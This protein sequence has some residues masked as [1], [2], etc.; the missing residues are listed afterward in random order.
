MPEISGICISRNKRSTSCLFKKS[1]A[2][3]ALVHFPAS[4]SSGTLLMYFSMTSSARGS[5]SIAR[6]LIIALMLFQV[7]PYTYLPSPLFSVYVFQDTEGLAFSLHCLTLCPKLR[8]SL[9]L[10]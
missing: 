2:S 3:L 10:Y 9:L 1:S 6:H 5:S 4:C 8:L 7:E